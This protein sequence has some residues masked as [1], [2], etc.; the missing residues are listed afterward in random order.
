TQ[1]AKQR[2]AALTDLAAKR[3]DTLTD[4]LAA[5]AASM[6]EQFASDLESMGRQAP[7]LKER[8]DSI[9]NDEQ[10]RSAGAVINF[11]QLEQQLRHELNPAMAAQDAKWQPEDQELAKLGDDRLSAEQ[12]KLKAELTA[13][14]KDL[15]GVAKAVSETGF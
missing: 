14:D 5:A 7:G 8:A 4:E 10:S 1:I 6:N 3:G 2:L 11:S 15:D 9:I 13:L 12:S